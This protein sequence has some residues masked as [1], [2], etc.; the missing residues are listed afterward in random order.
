MKIV[1]TNVSEVIEGNKA[2]NELENL[3]GKRVDIEGYGVQ[4][5]VKVYDVEI[6]GDTAYIYTELLYTGQKSKVSTNDIH[7]ITV[8][9]EE[10]V[11]IV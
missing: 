11:E 7:T 6:M 9:E 4:Y 8:F 5:G 3:V 10:A 2:I 1:K